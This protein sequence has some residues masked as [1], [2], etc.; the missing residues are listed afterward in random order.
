MIIATSAPNKFKIGA[1]LIKV[2]QK[3]EYSHVLIIDGD[4]VYQASHGLVNCMY[5]DN[6]LVD[7]KVFEKFNVAKE[8]IDMDFVK[9]QL[10]KKYSVKQILAIAVKYITGIKLFSNHADPKFICSEF[11]GQALRI[12]WVDDYTNPKEIAEYLTN[13]LKTNN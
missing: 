7:N 11:V 9:K 3:T 13:L 8:H 10:G 2:Y 6:F 12:P 1:W 4:L 5:I